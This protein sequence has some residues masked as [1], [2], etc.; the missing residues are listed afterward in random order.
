MVVLCVKLPD[1]PVIVTVAAPVDAVA[2]AVK[3]SMEVL[4]AGFTL[5]AAVT[6]L[7][8]PEAERVTLPL[9]PFEGLIVIMLVLWP[10]C[11]TPTVLGLV[12]SV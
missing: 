11:A 1:V 5:N 8:R 4:V 7:G 2:L 10:A 6:P 3:V 12:E 9:N